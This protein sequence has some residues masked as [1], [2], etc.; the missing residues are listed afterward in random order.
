M[1]ELTFLCNNLI[2]LIKCVCNS[3]WFHRS[4]L[5]TT[6]QAYISALIY[7]SK[8]LDTSSLHFLDKLDLVFP[9]YFFWLTTKSDIQRTLF[10]PHMRS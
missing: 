2:A 5:S 3:N 6:K 9:P 8:Q 1:V 4:L 10:S 7:L